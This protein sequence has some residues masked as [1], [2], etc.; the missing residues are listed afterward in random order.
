MNVIQGIKKA[1]YLEE[2]TRCGLPLRSISK[3]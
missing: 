2:N 1:N 3:H